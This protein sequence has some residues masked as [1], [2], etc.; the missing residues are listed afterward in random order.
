M[1]N[2]IKESLKNNL[3]G[4]LVSPFY[5]A[6]ITSWCVW[7][8]KVLYATL[9]IDQELLLI[10]K[11]VLKLDY[12]LNFYHYWFY[13]LLFLFVGPLFSAYLIVFIIPLV[14]KKFYKKSLEF[15]AENINIKTEIEKDTLKKKETRL[16]V[17]EKVLNIESDIE[18]KKKKAAESQAGKWNK[19][20]NEF[21]QSLVFNKMKEFIYVLYEKGGKT[22]EY[23]DRNGWIRTIS[24]D[25]LATTHSKGL[26][27]IK[28][29]G[30]KSK[31]TFELTEK[32][33]Y[34]VDKYLKNNTL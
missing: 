29:A 33:K 14:T 22:Y 6:L 30:N 19:E 8:W 20:F 34:F 15:E 21:R 2:E 1:L 17:E 28:E 5:G 31:E 13:N 4:K 9:F 7:N 11:G 12:I 18:D 10:E 25:I 23:N 3:L 26:V 27:D 32:G 16:E 24:S